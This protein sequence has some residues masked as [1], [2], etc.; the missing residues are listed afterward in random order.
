M[1]DI[2]PLG[3][4]KLKGIDK[5]NRILEL[6][7]YNQ[8]KTNNSNTN[9]AELVESTT[10][11]VY[12]IVKE[13]DGYYVKK[14]LNEQ[15][16]DYIGGMFMKNK[17]KFHSYAEAYKRMNLLKGQENLQE[18]NTK[19]VLKQNKPQQEAPVPAPTD[20]APTPLSDVAP[21]PAPSAEGGSDVPAAPTDDASH[22]SSDDQLGDDMSPTDDSSK[23]SDYMAE[24]QKFAGKLG[25]SLRDEKEKMES[26]DIKYV[27]N[28]V[29]SAVDIEKLDDEDKE[30]IADRFDPEAEESSEP[31]DGE[32]MPADDEASAEPTP[33]PQDELA[34]TMAKLE[35]LINTRLGGSKEEE[36]S[37]FN[38]S[39]EE[40]KEYDS[41]YTGEDEEELPSLGG[42]GN[43]DH[44]YTD[45]DMD[46]PSLGGPEDMDQEYGDDETEIDITPELSDEVNEAISTTLS[47]YFE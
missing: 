19:Y 13:K 11:G 3:S 5:M 14:G 6:T 8:Q 10:N 12:G 30:E 42:S 22:V 15:S 35:E 2:K 21:E 34:E 44:E 1:G 36:I 16:L 43:M 24:I 40:N 38:I 23:R 4:E 33:E 18:E 45:E 9:K 25:Q 17:N 28:M 46:L 29:L 41:A 27:I 32:E 37:E 39:S 31:N 26:D 7:Y 20:D 47:K